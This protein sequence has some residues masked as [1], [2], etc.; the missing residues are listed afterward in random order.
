MV[1]RIRTSKP[2]YPAK[3]QPGDIA[4]SLYRVEFTDGEVHEVGQEIVVTEEAVAYFNVCHEEY[5]K[6]DIPAG[7]A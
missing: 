5:S 2:P 4:I 1:G 3:F 7:V 6:K